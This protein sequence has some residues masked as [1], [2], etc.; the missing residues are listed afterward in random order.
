MCWNTSISPIVITLKSLK[1]I[2][3]VEFTN[4]KNKGAEKLRL[5]YKLNNLD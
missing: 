4:K 3:E 1:E 2:G 5:S